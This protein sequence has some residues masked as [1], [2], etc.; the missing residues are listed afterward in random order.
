MSKVLVTESY[1]T[2]IGNAIRA[3]SNSTTKYKPSVEPLPYI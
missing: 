1:L 2:D 3:K